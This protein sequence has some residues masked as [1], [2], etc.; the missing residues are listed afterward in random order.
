MNISVNRARRRSPGRVGQDP[1]RAR[2]RSPARVERF[3]L[4]GRGPNRARRR[5]SGVELSVSLDKA[6]IEL[7]DTRPASGYAFW[8]EHVKLVYMYTITT[9]TQTLDVMHLVCSTKIQMA[10]CMLM[11]DPWPWDPWPWVPLSTGVRPL[12]WCR[13]QRECLPEPWGPF[14]E[15]V[16]ALAVRANLKGH[17]CFGCGSQSQTPWLL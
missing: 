2:R 3:C 9:S 10:T 16:V 15:A 13:L 7:H 12:L 11:N 6:D 1:N 5:S 4:V 8:M 14:S 17:G